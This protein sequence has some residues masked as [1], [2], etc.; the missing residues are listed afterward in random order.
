LNEIVCE[1]GNN[2]RITLICP[3]CSSDGFARY[4]LDTIRDDGL[5]QGQCPKGHQFLVGTQTLRY[6]MLFDIALNAIRDRYYREAV[7]S[8]IASA[9]RFYEFAIR[10]FA[11]VHNL[12]PDLITNVWKQ[13]S[14]QSERQYGAY[15]LLYTCH[16]QQLPTALSPKMVELRN[17]VI[18]KGILPDKEQSV[19]F[20][21]EVYAVI[22]N[23]VQKLRAQY[24]NEVNAQL[25]EHVGAIGEKMGK[26]YPRS[27]M[28]TPTALNIIQDT[29]N[30]YK[31]FR[32]IIE[33]YVG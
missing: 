26:Q 11:R 4:F 9:E 12:S 17:N 13:V 27:F 31:P 1:L 23:G 24:L 20:G 29:S 22:Q 5:Y 6:E 33:R 2:M 14:N 15:V 28:V 32:E 7:S 25:S 21:E 16:F 8:F 18:H 19:R 30:G 3:E 10:V